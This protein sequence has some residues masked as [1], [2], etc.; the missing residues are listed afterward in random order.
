VLLTRRLTAAAAVLTAAVAVQLVSGVASATT[1]PPTTNDS[2]I[3]K[4]DGKPLDEHADNEKHVGCSFRVAFV[5]YDQPDLHAKVTFQAQQPTERPGTDQVLVQDVLL[6]SGDRVVKTYTLDFTGVTAHG[7]EGY[8][9]LLTIHIEGTEAAD[10]QHKLFWVTCCSPTP[11]PTPTKTPHPTNTPQP[12]NTVQPTSAPSP[13]P[14]SQVG[15]V[16]VGG[17]ETG[18][19]SSSGLGLLGLVVGGTLMV[20]GAA[21]FGSRR[22]RRTSVD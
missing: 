1:T 2:G 8:H 22:T 21:F 14:S 15:A 3:I 9:V 16:P 5:G 19:G 20:A 6:I 17:V 4:V 13:S 10:T 7:K 12:T 18:G 11:T